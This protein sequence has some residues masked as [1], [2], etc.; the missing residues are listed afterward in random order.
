MIS[1]VLALVFGPVSKQDLLK[2]LVDLPKLFFV[3]LVNVPLVLVLEFKVWLKEHVWQ[4]KQ[5]NTDRYTNNEW[6]S[7]D[8]EEWIQ[9][10]L[11]ACLVLRDYHNVERV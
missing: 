6:T 1:N 10:P 3:E 5:I 4:R 8:A 9:V 2:D 11:N 7:Y